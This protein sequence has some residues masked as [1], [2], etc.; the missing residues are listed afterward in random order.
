MVTELALFILNRKP[1]ICYGL[2][3]ML[4]YTVSYNGLKKMMHPDQT[5][6]N[7]FVCITLKVN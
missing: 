5:C 7:V 2:R 3:H 4:L 1:G 6:Q